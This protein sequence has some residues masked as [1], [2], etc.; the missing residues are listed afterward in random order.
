MSGPM[1]TQRETSLDLLGDLGRDEPELRI[2]EVNGVSQSLGLHCHLVGLGAL[3]LAG[4]QRPLAQ[5]HQLNQ[6]HNRLIA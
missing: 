5:S 1:G 3:L 6:L 2:E 4:L